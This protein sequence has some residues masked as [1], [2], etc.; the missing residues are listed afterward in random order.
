MTQS[1]HESITKLL[2]SNLVHTQQ[3][4]NITKLNLY[5]C[6]KFYE[7][8]FNTVVE[9]VQNAQLKIDNE[10]VNYV[11]QQYYDGTLINGKH[12]LDPNIFDKRATLDNV[13]TKELIVLAAMFKG[14]DFLSPVV[15]V[16]KSR[17]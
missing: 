10:A 11:A 12:E 8:I 4:H 3:T 2:E 5:A 7:S 14:T 9:V 16:L 17:N 1:V 15:K 13:P 6:T